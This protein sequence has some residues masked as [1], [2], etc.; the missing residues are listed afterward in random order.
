MSFFEL[1][2]WN[3]IPRLASGEQ[4]ASP[5]YLALAYSK[6]LK[7]VGFMREDDAA[8]VLFSPSMRKSIRVTRKELATF[9]FSDELPQAKVIAKMTFNKAIHTDMKRLLK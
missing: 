2:P 3:W 5:V 9:P 6:G 4:H 8:V 1:F 7:S